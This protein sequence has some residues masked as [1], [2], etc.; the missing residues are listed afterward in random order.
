MAGEMVTAVTTLGGVVLGGGLSVL[1]QNNS[2]RLE[3]RKQRTE[4]AEV[5]AHGQAVWRDLVGRAQG[6]EQG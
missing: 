4:L 1:V 6:A 3:Q 5:H 2:H